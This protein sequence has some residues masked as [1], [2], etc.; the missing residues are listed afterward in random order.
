MENKSL[1]KVLNSRERIGWVIYDWANSAFVLCVITVIGSAYFVARFE[2]AAQEAGGLMLGPSLAMDVGGMRLTAE[3]AWSLLI[4][5]SAAFVAISSPFLGS[6]ADRGG[7]KRQFL[8]VY[9]ALGV[10][11]TLAL[12]FPMP[13]WA[14]GLAILLGNI[15][16]EGGNVYYN[17]FLPHLA[18]GREQDS[19]SS[20]GYAFGYL[21]SVMVL[22]AA[23]I[24]F[25]PPRGEVTDSFLMVGLWWGGFALL[26]LA[27]VRD[28]SV[29]NTRSFGQLAS[30]SWREVTTTIAHLKS[31]RDLAVFLLAFLLYNDAIATLIS[32]ATPFALENIYLDE[33]L[34]QKITLNEL[35]PA[36]IMIQV[37]AFPGSILCGWLSLKFGEKPTIY[38]TIAVFLVVV[39]LGLFI[40]R[41]M[42]FYF[43][44]VLVG[45]VLGGSQAISRALFAAMV[46]P[47][48]ST[49]FFAFFAL[50]SKFS[51]MLGPLV[52]GGLLLLTGDTRLAIMSLSVFLVGGGIVLFFVNVE[53]GRK[54][55]PGERL[56]QDGV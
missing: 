16:F 34:T 43:I 49:E 28:S 4:G 10:A 9:C 1:W 12:W 46:P 6:I 52:Y 2:S 47:E 11:A 48:K 39:I 26:S 35:I 24:F 25:V 55:G 13:W 31:H 8:A 40:N 21:G 18:R 44:S 22:I 14:V 20:M 38:F 15:G 3:A 7:W 19:L 53:R 5:F 50:S 45:L 51:A 41:V 17:A 32:N 27:W 23:L 33:A 54:G 56:A 29:S 42:E 30:G 37:I 36:I